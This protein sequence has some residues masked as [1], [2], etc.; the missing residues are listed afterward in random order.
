M[1][2][3]EITIAITVYDRRAYI[4]QAVA[5]ALGQTAPVRVMV[6]E[7][8]GPDPSLQAFVL[9]KFGSRV[10]YHR[11]AQRR[12]LFDN[13]NACIDLC[14]TAWLC[15]CHDDDFL[16]PC[17]V[18]AMIE[19]ADKIPGKGLYY[20]DY[21]VRNAAG[22]ILLARVPPPELRCQATEVV[23]V[24]KMNPLIFPS[25]LFRA[26][27]AKA[28]GG[29]RKTSLFTGDWD[30]W[31][32]L[33]LFYGAARTDRVVGNAR[34]HEAAGRGTTRIERNGK[35]LA[36][37]NMQCKKNLALLRP[38]GVNVQ[39]DRAAAQRASDISLRYILKFGAGWSP[40]L[41]RYN[42]GLVLRSESPGFQRWV[43]RAFAR[44]FGPGFLRAA[45]AL[46]RVW[47]GAERK[48]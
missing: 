13:W 45:S 43:F 36:L 28:L 17:F 24:A 48:T 42:H 46:W 35:F 8:C 30:M 2:P 18:E 20:G 23:A 32:K 22:E 12:G 31:V 29:F 33:T 44:V 9:G 34:S 25:I 7:D 40:L 26:D 41:L 6:V 27:Y 38:R 3:D 4:E 47:A 14:R 19:L 1:R 16:E 21:N 15:I 11:N 39:F 5:A 37:V 10:T